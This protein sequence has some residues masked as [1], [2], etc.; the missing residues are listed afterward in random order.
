VLERMPSEAERP[1]VAREPVRLRERIARLVARLDASDRVSFREWVGSS[2]SRVEVVVEFLAVLEL[3]KVRY[4]EAE[5]GDAF[6]DIALVRIAG[7]TA[8]TQALEA[9]LAEDFA[10]T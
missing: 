2:K 5:Q 9:Q 8:P 6:G 10:G 4:L 3:I 1:A 7:A